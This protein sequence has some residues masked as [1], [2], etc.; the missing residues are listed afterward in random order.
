MNP[1]MNMLMGQLQGKNPQGFQM[2]N[3]MMNN[4]ANPQNIIKQMLGN[5]N[6]SQFQQIMQQAKQMGC[7]DNILSQIQNMK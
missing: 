5:T 6:S 4:G 7:P 2:L 3:Q 1:I